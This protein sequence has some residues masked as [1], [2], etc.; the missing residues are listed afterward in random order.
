MENVYF[1]LCF[2]QQTELL[3]YVTSRA[4]LRALLVRLG[5]DYNYSALWNIKARTALC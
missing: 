4:L 1:R 3:F 2:M 5:P